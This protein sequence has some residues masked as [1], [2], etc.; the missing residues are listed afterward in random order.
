LAETYSVVYH[1]PSAKPSHLLVKKESPIAVTQ[2]Q[3]TAS[4]SQAP[5][6]SSIKV[7]THDSIFTSQKSTPS[8]VAGWD[9]KTFPPYLIH[10]NRNRLSERGREK[11]V[12]SLSLLLIESSL[13]HHSTTHQAILS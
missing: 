11:G 5:W 1:H 9:G 8:F 10:T 2:I 13:G 4:G 6:Q 3:I 7:L 12:S